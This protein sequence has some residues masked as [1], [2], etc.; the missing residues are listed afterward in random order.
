M[1]IEWI[2]NGDSLLILSPF[3]II[4]GKY[5]FNFGNWSKY[6][7]I[8]RSGF[9]TLF[10]SSES[11]LFHHVMLIWVANTCQLEDPQLFKG[12]AFYP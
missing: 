10:N 3:G 7:L 8:L 9:S 1:N 4:S 5:T 2:L 12:T 6:Y 11:H